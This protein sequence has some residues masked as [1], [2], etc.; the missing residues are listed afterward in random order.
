M[1]YQRNSV[2]GVKGRFGLFTIIIIFT[3]QKLKHLIQEVE[4][5]IPTKYHDYPWTQNPVPSTVEPLGDPCTA[6]L[7]TPPFADHLLS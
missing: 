4:F 3:V 1:S 5:P 7:S 6:H 2:H